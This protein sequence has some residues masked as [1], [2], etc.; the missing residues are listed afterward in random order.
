MKTKPRIL[1]VEDE[2]IIAADVASML[3]RIGHEV[4]DVA[5]TGAEAIAKAEQLLPDLVLMDIMLADEMDGVTAADEIRRRFH[6]PV[7]FLT[8]HTDPA[9]LGRAKLTEPYGY[10]VKPLNERDLRVGIEMALHKHSMEMRL[11]ESEAWFSTTLASIGDA[12]IATDAEGRVRFLNPVARAITG[13]TADEARGR[14]LA[15]VMVFTSDSPQ[16]KPDP[17]AAVR[18]EGVVIEWTSRIWL[19]PR[20]DGQRTPIDYTAAPIRGL[21]GLVAGIVV[22]FRDISLRLQAEGERERL[23]SELKEALDKVKTLSGF[24][25]ICSQCKKIREDRD[26]WVQV[27]AYV[28]AHS[29]AKFTHTLCPVCM[30]FLYPEFAEEILDEEAR[31]R[32]KEGPEPWRARKP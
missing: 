25:P 10:V 14:P 2:G 18:T 21:D 28:A 29:D 20:N 13:W 26:Y 8:A 1:I 4:A 31:N 19:Q 22:V 5:S 24:I 11:A 16:A 27:E 12:L 15:E 30:R 32:A 7:V 6:L 9:M 23:I 3:C 17:F